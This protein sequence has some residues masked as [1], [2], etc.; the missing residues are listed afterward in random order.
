MK[1]SKDS[2]PKRDYVNFFSG[3]NLQKQK[4]ASKKQVGSDKGKDASLLQKDKRRKTTAKVVTKTKMKKQPLRIGD[5]I[6][7]DQVPDKMM[8]QKRNEDYKDDAENQ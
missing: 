5:S 6:R 2:E 7:T 1:P 4:Q 3:A 8:L